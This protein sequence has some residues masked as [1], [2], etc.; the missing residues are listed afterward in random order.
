MESQSLSLSTLAHLIIQLQK[1]EDFSNSVSLLKCIKLH[2]YNL[3]G[4][5]GLKMMRYD[6][7]S[8]QVGRNNFWTVRQQAVKTPYYNRI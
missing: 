4:G 5:N 8:K 3:K 6:I 1:E 7:L 2:N